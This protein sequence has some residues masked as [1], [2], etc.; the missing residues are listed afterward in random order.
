MGGLVEGHDA[1]LVAGGQR[2]RGAQ[3]RLLADVRLAHALELAAAAHPAV[4]RVAVA[5]VHRARLV[6]DDDEGDVRLA[7]GG[8][9]TPMSTGSVSSIGVF[10]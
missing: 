9:R 6:D 2:R 4:E 7:S 10:V 3:D 8:S 1:E 5:G